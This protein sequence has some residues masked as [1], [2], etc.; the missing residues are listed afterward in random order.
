MIMRHTLLLSLLVLLC[1]SSCRAE[2]DTFCFEEAGRDYGIS[3]Q[4]LEAVSWAESRHEPAALHINANGSTDYGHMQ[5]NSLWV[6]VIGETY[7]GLED[8]CFCT[9]VGAYILSDCIERYGYNSNALSCYNSGRPL[10]KLKGETRK[11][12]VDYVNS[13]E[14]RYMRLKQ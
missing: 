8:P 14:T 10:D 7:L 5:I 1:V 4:L 9:K 12:V 6:P 3:P 2:T 13:V 11:R